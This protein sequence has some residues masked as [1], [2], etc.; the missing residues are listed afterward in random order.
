VEPIATAA[1]AGAVIAASGTAMEGPGVPTTGTIEEGTGSD[2]FAVE[3]EVPVP[4]AALGL[5]VVPISEQRVPATNS[6]EILPGSISEPVCSMW[7]GVVGRM[8]A[9]FYASGEYLLWWTSR[10]HAPILATT[11]NPLEGPVAARLGQPDTVILNDGTL[12]NEPHSGMRFTAGYFVDDCCTKAIEVGGF[13]L[14]RE[15]G[16]F[17][18]SSAEFPVL[19]RPFFSLNQGI[20]RVQF[21]AFPGVASG[22]LTI[23]SPSELWGVE[24][25]ARCMWCC[26]CDYSVD[27]LAGARY[28]NLREALTITENTQT[29]P[30]VMGD[31]FNGTHFINTDSFATRNQFYGGQ[32]GIEAQKEWG[33]LSIDGVAKLAV[34]A[35]HQELSIQGAQFFPPGTPNVDPRPGGLFALDS[36]IGNYSRNRFSVVP[37]VGVTLGWY[38][39]SNIQLSVGYNFLY[40][41][42]VVRPGEQIDRNLDINRIPNFVPPPRPPD[43]PG[44][45]PS[46]L[47]KDS[48]FWAQGLTVGL[49]F[50]F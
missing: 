22:T 21:V 3:R 2:L 27:L 33:R 17:S 15:S 39:T 37:E 30:G 24:A 35:T 11:G 41:T 13:F 23:S 19:A 48:D 12:G 29:V 7:D 34:G 4:A 16:Q 45:H 28:L 26:G 32:I 46:V 10:D 20:E 18:A 43:L 14:P 49:R 6:F 9:G 40:W 8:P 47:F 50:T 25:N 42:N 31:P 36:N 38:V 1:P 44:L 5:Q